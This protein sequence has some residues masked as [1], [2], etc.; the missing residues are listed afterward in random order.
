MCECRGG[1]ARYCARPPYLSPR[2]ALTRH[3]SPPAML[4][5]RSLDSFG[6]MGGRRRGAHT[7]FAG[8]RNILRAR[9]L[10][11]VFGTGDFIGC[12]AMHRQQDAA[13]LDP[14]LI[15]FRFI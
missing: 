11:D 14:A 7:L 4:I 8:R 1:E 15:P 10:Q 3:R 5:D 12:I 13:V 2:S 9:P 6:V